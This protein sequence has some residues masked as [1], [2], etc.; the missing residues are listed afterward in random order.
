MKRQVL[1][2]NVWVE[3]VSTVLFVLLV[4][5][6]PRWPHASQHQNLW[7]NLPLHCRAKWAPF[8]CLASLPLTAFPICSQ[9]CTRKVSPNSRSSG[10]ICMIKWVILAEQ[11]GKLVNARFT[12]HKTSILRSL[13]LL[14]INGWR[15][16][17]PLTIKNN[18]FDYRNDC[19]LSLS[20]SL[21]SRNGTILSWLGI[22]ETTVELTWLMFRETISGSLT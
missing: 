5:H 17:S 21:P 11:L 1:S 18:S 6:R 10:L 20:P 2:T 15:R 7:A 12:R 4:P 13:K 9:T 22:P 3:Q 14:R 16:R 19:S 8:W